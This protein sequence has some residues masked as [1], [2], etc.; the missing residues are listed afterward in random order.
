MIC[1]ISADSALVKSVK[2]ASDIIKPRDNIILLSLFHF[3]G[4]EQAKNG[5][6]IEAKKSIKRALWCNAASVILC[7]LTLATLFVFVTIVIVVPR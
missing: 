7:S 2:V 3:Q 4:Q 5:G 1:T 6:I